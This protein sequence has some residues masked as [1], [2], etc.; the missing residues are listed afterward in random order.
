[1]TPQVRLNAGLNIVG[2]N[3]KGC[4]YKDLEHITN[5]PYILMIYQKYIKL[6][7]F[8]KKYYKK[9]PIFGKFLQ[10]FTFL[11]V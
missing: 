3:T 4:F 2:G 8:V 1:M 11:D 9:Y 5:N 7:T 10:N 6:N